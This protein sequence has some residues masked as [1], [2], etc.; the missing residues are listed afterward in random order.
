MIVKQNG[1]LTSVIEELLEELATLEIEEMQVDD[2]VKKQQSLLNDIR[3][4]RRRKE[5]ELRKV[6]TLGYKPVYDKDGRRICPGDIVYITNSFTRY[7]VR[8]EARIKSVSP[9]I[10]NRANYDCDRYAEIKSFERVQQGGK[11]V[12]RVNILTDA[13]LLTWRLHYNLWKVVIEE[14]DDGE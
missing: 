4:Q 12:D 7:S 14:E 8:E 6:R 3:T 2:E 5:V 9:S 11:N 10:K 13:S 1:H